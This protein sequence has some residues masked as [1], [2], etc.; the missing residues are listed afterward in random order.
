MI[1]FRTDCDKTRTSNRLQNDFRRKR[2][3]LS[4]NVLNFDT[5]ARNTNSVVLCKEYLKHGGVFEEESR[6]TEKEI[7]FLLRRH[8]RKNTSQRQNKEKEKENE[9]MKKKKQETA[10]LSRDITFITH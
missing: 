5:F 6:T 4:S 2:V 7:I 9:K 1:S 8:G 3:P 10:P